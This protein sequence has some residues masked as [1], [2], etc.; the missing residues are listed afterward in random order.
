MNPS[1]S[2]LNRRQLE[3]V[4]VG[5]LLTLLATEF[6]LKLWASRQAAEGENSA[7]AGAILGGL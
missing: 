6:L 3:L 7:I 2:G 4:V 5:S 1:R